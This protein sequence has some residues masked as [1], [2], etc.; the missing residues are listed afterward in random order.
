MRPPRFTVRRLMAAVACV[1]LAAGGLREGARLKR[2]SEEYNRRA[3][4]IARRGEL[5][6][7]NLALTQADWEAKDLA[8]RQANEGSWYK[9]GAGPSPE[10]CRKLAPYFA[11]LRQKYERAAR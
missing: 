7:R 4:G 1:A 8:R 9:W 2:L 10:R 6:R 11:T 5:C 3:I